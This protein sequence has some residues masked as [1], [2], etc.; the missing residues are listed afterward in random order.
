MGIR[1]RVE[2]AYVTRWALIHSAKN[3]KVN[4]LQSVPHG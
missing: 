4:I 2:S 1:V 3:K